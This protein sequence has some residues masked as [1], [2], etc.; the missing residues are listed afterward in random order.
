VRGPL[1]SHVSTANHYVIGDSVRSRPST[2]RLLLSPPPISPIATSSEE[3]KEHENNQNEVHIFLPTIPDGVS[4]LDAS[5]GI[6]P[7]TFFGDGLSRKLVERGGAGRNNFEQT[8]VVME[9]VGSAVS[10]TMAGLGAEGVTLWCMGAA[11][12]RT[13]PSTS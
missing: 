11:Q 2:H 12:S 9:N 8:N 5:L 4:C 3:E 13:C 7:L 6:Y 10:T 1:A